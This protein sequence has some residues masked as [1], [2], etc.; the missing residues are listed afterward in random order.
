MQEIRKLTKQESWRFFS[1]ELNHADSLSRGSRGVE[2][3][4]IE[5]WWN[6]LE[7]P[8]CKNELWPSKQDSTKSDDVNALVE[9]AK[10]KTFQPQQDL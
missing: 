8:G 7:F 3:T 4:K 10:P 9:M 2:L 6:G 1:G 5:T